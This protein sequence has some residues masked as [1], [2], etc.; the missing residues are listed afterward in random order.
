M[1]KIPFLFLFALPF[2]RASSQS[3][4]VTTAGLAVSGR[5]VEGVATETAVSVARDNLP[6][7]VVGSAARMD[8][9]F[10][11]EENTGTGA[12]VKTATV[13]FPPTIAALAQ[14]NPLS[15]LLKM[16]N[17]NGALSPD[18][19]CTNGGVPVLGGALG[20]WKIECM[21]EPGANF[22]IE[23]TVDNLPLCEDCVVEASFTDSDCSPPA[24][25]SLRFSV[26]PKA[27]RGSTMSGRR[28]QDTLECSMAEDGTSCTDEGNKCT[29]DLC[30]AGQCTHPP[31]SNTAC[32]GCDLSG[33]GFCVCREGSCQ[34]ISAD[35][36]GI[37][38]PCWTQIPFADPVVPD[39][40]ISFSAGDFRFQISG[41]GRKFISYPASVVA[42]QPDTP[43]GP[44]TFT[45]VIE[46]PPAGSGEPPSPVYGGFYLDA[47]VGDTTGDDAE[48]LG[49]PS[50]GQSFETGS[51]NDA[52]PTVTDIDRTLANLRRE[53]L[54]STNKVRTEFGG[55]TDAVFAL[56]HQVEVPAGQTA[57]LLFSTYA[58]SDGPPTK[59]EGSTLVL[60]QSDPAGAV[61]Q[62][63]YFT[64]SACLV[65]TSLVAFAVSSDACGNQPIGIPCAADPALETCM[66]T[67]CVFDFCVPLPGEFFGEDFPWIYAGNSC[68]PDGECSRQLCDPEGQCNS[69]PFPINSGQPCTGGFCLAG[70]CA[71]ATECIG[72]ADG[73]VC[74]DDGD[75][76]TDDICALGQCTHPL[77]DSPDCNALNRFRAVCTGRVSQADAASI[78]E[79]SG[80]RLAR[81]QSDADNGRAVASLAALTSCR[82]SSAGAW[83]A[84]TDAASEGQF[85]FPS[86]DPLFYFNWREG[87]P[88]NARDDEDCIAIAMDPLL[89]GMWNDQTCD[90]TPY[91]AAIC[92]SPG[93]PS[94]FTALCTGGANQ[95]DAALVCEN[96]SL[97]LA[98]I[99]TAGDNARAAA[100]LAF[101]ADCP[102]G[103]S[104]AWIGGSDEVSEGS[105]VFANGEPLSY[106]NWKAG[107]PNN[108]GGNDSG[109]ENCIGLLSGGEWND[110]SCSDT[111]STSVLCEDPAECLGVP[112]GTSCADD[113]NQCTDDVCTAGECTHIPSN[114]VPC[115]GPLLSLFTTTPGG[116]SFN[117]A[118]LNGRNGFTFSLLAGDS[119]D[120]ADGVGDVNNDGIDDVIVGGSGRSGGGGSG[121]R[122]GRERGRDRRGGEEEC[123]ARPHASLS[124]SLLEI[125]HNFAGVVWVIYGKNVTGE[126]FFSASVDPES[127]TGTTGFRI[128]GGDGGPF[129]GENLNKGSL[130][131][132]LN[133]DGIDDFVLGAPNAGRGA[134]SV[135]V[136]FGRQSTDPFPSPFDLSSLDGSN[137]FVITPASRTRFLGFS[138]G[139][140]GD[141]NGDG[142]DDL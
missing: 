61:S 49:S 129:F 94:R 53:S 137:G 134:G 30:S 74:T 135:W 73:T 25:F 88:S 125:G 60:K 17:Q 10:T 14:Q 69:E 1:W 20:E 108:D 109:N 104:G 141:L 100:S 89:G 44:Q 87:E 27:F 85:V 26:V 79:S 33:P 82:G 106:F 98:R 102:G 24:I 113:G 21:T 23:V 120:W 122:K 51:F 117:A 110:L 65:D 107:E 86:A 40:G 11:H 28:L 99:R 34:G 31:L 12:P 9:F 72:E 124:L 46:G 38:Q 78:C 119:G 140:A 126:G 90:R 77:I 96:N 37:P 8:F 127:L 45:M 93:P 132:D 68:G 18:T 64:S 118:D 71:E 62:D 75:D 80:R 54:S 70:V 116:T 83:I 6:V 67:F 103:S 58:S 43:L 92:E 142:L 123:I 112:D 39:P 130:A 57:I 131:G 111:L 136:V 52:D 32:E 138:V 48:V 56:S 59:L 105:F 2:H 13:K 63:F 121:R 97:R 35:T 22:S 29:A 3:D 133:G 95:A 91:S 7:S 41:N 50:P 36:R 84:G 101:Q 115:N 139:L 128:D 19:D 5:L 47:N 55:A 4:C 42:P 66:G 114:N 16:V 76:C 15:I 81:I